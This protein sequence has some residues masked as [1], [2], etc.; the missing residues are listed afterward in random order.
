MPIKKQVNKGYLVGVEELVELMRAVFASA[1]LLKYRPISINFVSKPGNGKTEL[2]LFFDFEAE[3][4]Q[5]MALTELSSV[6]VTNVLKRYSNLKH[7]I[8]PD[9]TRITMKKKSTSDNLVSCLNA[10]MEEGLHSISLQNSEMDFK[11]RQC[12]IVTAITTDSYGQNKA[13]FQ[14]IGLTSRFLIVSYDYNEETKQKILESIYRSEW[15]EK[16]AK[17]KLRTNSGKKLR[18]THVKM[19]P[20]LAKKLNLLGRNPFRTQKQLQTLACAC[21]LLDDRKEV[22]DDDIIKVL[23]FN[24]FFNLEYTKI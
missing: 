5:A 21:A 19:S 8:I 11:G 10:L 20:E 7:I 22:N 3:N 24:R 17:I 9:L 13:K 18:L 16:H 1:Y 23:N 12:G 14:S 15:L 4:P 2:A 6:G